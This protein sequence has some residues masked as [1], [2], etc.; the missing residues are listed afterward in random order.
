MRWLEV[1]TTADAIAR[2]LADHDIAPRAPPAPRPT[3]AEQLGLPFT[4]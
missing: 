2:A 4:V 3:V 1:A